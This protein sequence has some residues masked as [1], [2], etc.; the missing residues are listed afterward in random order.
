MCGGL[1]V[2]LDVVSIETGLVI[3]VGGEPYFHGCGEISKQCF[4]LSFPFQDASV[5]SGDSRQASG[6]VLLHKDRSRSS[7][8]PFG[9]W[10]T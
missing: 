10:K 7:G 8:S 3:P 9:H 6:A 1:V 5:V 4:S 2:A